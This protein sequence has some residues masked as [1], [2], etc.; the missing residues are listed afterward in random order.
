MKNLFQAWFGDLKTK[1]ND[2]VFIFQ[3]KDWNTQ[4]AS[5]SQF[6]FELVIHGGAPSSIIS[7]LFNGQLVDIHS[8]VRPGTTINPT[9]ST[10]TFQTESS[11]TISAAPITSIID[12]KYNY[13]GVLHAS[14]LFYEAQ[15]AGKLPA[16]NR[17]SWRG[18]S[19]NG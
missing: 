2:Q 8:D 13:E 7:V 18:D 14:L 19:I 11:S 1:V 17:I 5:G 12:G 3:N 16:N 10:P 15:R 9:G 6:D 4:L